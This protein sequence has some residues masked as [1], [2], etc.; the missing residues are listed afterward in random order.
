T[1]GKRNPYSISLRAAQWLVAFHTILGPLSGLL[2]KL[3]N[4]F[5]PGEDFRDG[6]YSTEVELREMVDIAQEKGV[7]ETTEGRMIQNIF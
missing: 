7:V 1:A 3:G 4:V 5:H 2:I 6:P